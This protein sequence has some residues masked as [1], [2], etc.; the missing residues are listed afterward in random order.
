LSTFIISVLIHLGFG[1]LLYGLTYIFVLFV[2]F[3]R[4]GHPFLPISELLLLFFLFSLKNV[5]LAGD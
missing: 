1:F 2:F 5:W 3:L 4:L